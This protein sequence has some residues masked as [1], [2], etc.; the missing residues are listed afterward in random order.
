VPLVTRAEFRVG[1]RRVARDGKAPYVKRIAARRFHG[2]RSHMYRI[3]AR[4]R[5]RDGR[6]A[7]RSTRLRVCARSR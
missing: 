4:A 7:R 6:L 5:L 3:G 2:H 1:K